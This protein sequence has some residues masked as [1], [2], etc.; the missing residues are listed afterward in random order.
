[1]QHGITLQDLDSNLEVDAIAA[2]TPGSKRIPWLG[3][4]VEIN[5]DDNLV[6]FK[7]LHSEG[8]RYVYKDDDTDWVDRSS[9][10]C[11][12]VILEPIVQMNKVLW[13][14]VTPMEVIRAMNKEKL[15]LIHEY[16]FVYSEIRKNPWNI[17]GE[18]FK[19]MTELEAY[20]YKQ[21]E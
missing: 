8:K 2:V 5:L 6:C 9:V 15:E 19:N 18:Q 14:L 12:G 11:T 16:E 17:K 10:I 13:K 3:R 20:L 4:I 7:W 21:T 1:M